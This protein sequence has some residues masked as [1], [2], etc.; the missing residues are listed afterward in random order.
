MRFG[1]IVSTWYAGILI[2]FASDVS[3][4]DSQ[5]L[6]P[7]IPEEGAEFGIGVDLDGLHNVGGVVC[8]DAS[9]LYG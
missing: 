6:D 7:P 2:A 4:A 1:A 8:S 9:Y 3:L 5:W